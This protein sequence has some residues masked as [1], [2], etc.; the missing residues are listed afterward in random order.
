MVNWRIGCSGFHYKHWKERFYPRDLPQ[1]KWF[2]YYCRHFSTVELNV[3]FYRFPR[4]SALQAWYDRSP[5]AFRFAVKAPRGITHFKQFHHTEQLISDFYGTVGEGL[6]DKLGCVL[7][8]LPPRMD[9]GEERLYRILDALD[10]A[11]RNVLEFR[12][13][14]WWNPEVF[15]A[16]SRRQVTFCGMSHPALP[17]VVVQSTPVLYYRFHGVP[18]LYRSP[19]TESELGRFSREVSGSGLTREAF[20]YFNNDIDAS[21]I[22]NAQ[23]LIGLAA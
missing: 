6:K 3:T 16:L 20:I 5:D 1:R 2:E 8:Q 22:I 10:P 14:S 17:A 7:F 12:H 21:A 13:E 18:E 23:Q 4:L 15:D 19:Y 11:F 9:Y